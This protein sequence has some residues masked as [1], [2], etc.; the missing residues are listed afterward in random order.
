MLTMA[1]EN[2]IGWIVRRDLSTQFRADR[3]A[4]A[5]HYYASI[6]NTLTQAVTVGVDWL[7]AK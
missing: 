6:G 2:Q 5:S 3:A 1:E 4:G 7:V